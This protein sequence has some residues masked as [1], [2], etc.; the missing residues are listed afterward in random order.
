MNK[1]LYYKHHIAASEKLILFVSIL[2][3]YN[4]KVD[5]EI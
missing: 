3:T 1:N 4:L 5:T 2:Q